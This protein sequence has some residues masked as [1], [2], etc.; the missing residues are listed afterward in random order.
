VSCFEDLVIFVTDVEACLNRL[1][2]VARRFLVLSIFQE[3]SKEE[4]A[5]RLG[6][7]VRNARR[8]YC[9][10]IDELS[11]ILLRFKVLEPSDWIGDVIAAEGWFEGCPVLRRDAWSLQQDLPPKKP[12]ATARERG[13]KVVAMPARVG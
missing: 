9:D 8:I 10:A 1:G 7:E 12:S 11:E 13:A 2:D 6:C 4:S 3:Y 5:A